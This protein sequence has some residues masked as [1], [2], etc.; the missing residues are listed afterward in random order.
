MHTLVIVFDLWHGEKVG[1]GPWGSGAR[2]S[3]T[4]DPG[5]PQSLKVEP[6]T[7]PKV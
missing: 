4:R 6:G 7:P 5:P 1:P 2:D 3:W